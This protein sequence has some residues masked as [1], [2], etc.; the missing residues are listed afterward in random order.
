MVAS[1]RFS[2]WLNGLGHGK[3]VFKSDQEPSIIDVL[4]LIRGQR[5]KAT[6]EIAINVGSLRRMENEWEAALI[7]LES[8]PVGESKSNGAIENAIK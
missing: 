4:R 7:V 2:Q 1:Q 8:S 6:E 3:V 5:I